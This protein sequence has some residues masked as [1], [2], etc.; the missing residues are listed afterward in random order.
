MNRL[1]IHYVEGEDIS[2]VLERVKHAIESGV[3]A[4][5]NSEFNFTLDS[6]NTDTA[7]TKV[8]ARVLSFSDIKDK[9]DEELMV[10]LTH[11]DKFVDLDRIEAE[12]ELGVD[13]DNLPDKDIVLMSRPYWN[14]IF[15]K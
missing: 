12:I 5:K 2:S 11:K 13:V 6:F 3:T 1:L 4:A 15:V 10:Y 14:N 9:S 7:R 8:S